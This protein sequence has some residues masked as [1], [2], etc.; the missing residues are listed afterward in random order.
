MKQ[1]TRVGF[2]QALAGY[3]SRAKAAAEAKETRFAQRHQFEVAYRRAR[4]KVII[5][6]L[7]QI[8]EEILEPRG[9]K[10]A[11]RSVE[12]TIEATLE[13]YRTDQKTVSTGERPF[14]SFKAA[15]HAAQFTVTSS[16]QSQGGP[17]G[18]RPLEELSE[19]FVHQC[20]LEFF[21]VLAL[22]RR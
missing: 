7:K 4:D 9:W 17:H 2:E 14:I 16:A 18:A 10:C 21:Q 20:V 12:Q 1:E 8:A 3:E 15:P 22:G 13:I 6:A 19:E 5:P 11:V